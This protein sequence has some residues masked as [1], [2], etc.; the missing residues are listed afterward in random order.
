MLKNLIVLVTLLNTLVGVGQ[1]VTNGSISGGAAANSGIGAGNA[2][3]WTVCQFSPD[4]C[5]PSRPS[6]LTTSQVT[7]S[8]SPDGGNWLGLASMSPIGATECA[9]STITGL[10]IGNSYTLCFYAACFGT[11]S[12]ICNNSPATP[13]VSVG[14]TSQLYTIPMA[15]ST[16]VACS[17]P[18]TATANTMVLQAKHSS[19]FGAYYAY[20]G[21]DGFYIGTCSVLPIELLKFVLTCDQDVVNVS[22]ITETEISNDFFTIERSHDGVNFERL[23]IIA[24]SG[25][26]TSQKTYSWVD[27]DPLSGT[28]YYRLSQSDFNGNTEIFEIQ[29][30]SCNEDDKFVI[31]PSP[32]TDVLNIKYDNSIKSIKI[33]DISGKLIIDVYQDFNAID[34]SELSNGI[35]FLKLFTSDRV[36]T[37][38]FFKE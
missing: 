20:V 7:P 5:D 26:S 21:L 1:T 14:A 4:V 35:Y 17:L 10:T 30:V 23:T 37:K 18:F 24:G 2:P 31:Y 12:T 25:T 11:A 9:Q 6:Y 33:T 29:S 8:F 15:A 27:E 3:G 32:A 13:T 36:L 28:S 22:W 19:T 16:W 38:K 34:V